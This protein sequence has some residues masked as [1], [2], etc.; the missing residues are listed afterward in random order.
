MGQAKQRGT[1]TERI[2]STKVKRQS[3]KQN[4]YQILAE[5]VMIDLQSSGNSIQ[6]HFYETMVAGVDTLVMTALGGAAFAF[7]VQRIDDLIGSD[8]SNKFFNT[9]GCCKSISMINF[10]SSSIPF[11][12]GVQCFTAPYD[13]NNICLL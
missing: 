10:E 2:E 6:K 11:P 7:S 9:F 8:A 5:T 12:A 4:G 3:K 1:R 13:K